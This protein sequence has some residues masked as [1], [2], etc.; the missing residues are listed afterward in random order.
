MKRTTPL[1]VV[2]VVAALAL[3]TLA[4]S[5][6]T[7]SMVEQVVI[8]QFGKP[9]PGSEKI[10]PGLHFKTPF[11]QTVNRVE[12][13]LISWD[14][15]PNPLVT[16]DKKNI[17]VDSY[18]RWRVAKPL[19]FL[20]S[21]QGMID[22]GQK[23]LDDIIDS[24]VRNV[25][26][27]YDL[28]E[29]VRTTNNELVYESEELAAEQRARAEKIEVGRDKMMREIR[30]EAAGLLDPGLGIE[31]T[32]VRIKRVNY[33]RQEVRQSLYENMIAERQRIAKRYRSEAQEKADKILGETNREVLLISGEAEEKKLPGEEQPH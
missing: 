15:E 19:A 1:V 33:A 27:K 2:G 26:G 7:V 12:K 8:T 25:V 5:V 22:V 23:K 10:G 14:G 28:I 13:R 32:D 4:S 21:C 31:V 11:V 18:A 30:D 16:R 20:T 17:F 29:V 3:L 9:I 6:Y 24:A